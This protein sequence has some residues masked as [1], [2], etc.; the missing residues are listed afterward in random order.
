M[1]SSIW[2]A[3]PAY[4]VTAWR[5]RFRR[6][7]WAGWS[8]AASLLLF[9]ALAG[10]GLGVLMTAP[11][12]VPPARETFGEAWVADGESARGT[13][14]GLL[15][16]QVTLIG[17]VLSASTAA[18]YGLVANQ[19]LRLVRFIGPTR[20]LFHALVGFALTTGY[21][22][23]AVRRLGPPEVEAPRPVV[24]V[25]VVLAVAAIVA[26]IV[27]AALALQ[28]Q[29]IARMLR[30]VARATMRAIEP[31]RARSSGGPAPAGVE[32]AGVSRAL[33]APRHGYV[34]DVDATRLLRDAVR[35]DARVR[36]DRAVGDYV[37]AGEPIGVVWA[38]SAL[39]PRAVRQLAGTLLIEDSRSPDLDVTAGLRVL[40]DIAERALSPAVNDPY[41]ACEV[42][43]RLR[44]LLAELAAVP[45][46][47]WLLRD[48]A[49]AV[50][51]AIARPSFEELLRIAAD[52]PS[53]YGAADPDVL[54]ALLELAAA[55]GRVPS[56]CGAAHQL[57]ARVLGDAAGSGMSA[58]RRALLERKARLVLADLG[59]SAAVPRIW[60][61]PTATDGSVTPP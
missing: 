27:D 38:R 18:L 25:G 11:E 49:G 19:S 7:A 1:R 59:G 13:L 23:A 30:I 32:D 57:V 4:A 42:L 24:T 12:I 20:P 41:T 17:L 34:V 21:V 44:G 3:T 39:P 6:V 51:V 36:V 14:A 48:A 31:H 53:R 56:R 52:G 15:G 8:T 16:V 45:D 9:A 47:D 40:V 10:A 35:L 37:A 50:R 58:E 43:H 26:V 33:R 54:D 29:E 22:L 61:A 28:K 5:E 46:G 60:A 55:I 2:A